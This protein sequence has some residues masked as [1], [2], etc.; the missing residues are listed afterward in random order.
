MIRR[1]LW[2]TPGVWLAFFEATGIEPRLTTRPSPGPIRQLEFLTGDPT[3]TISNADV[4]AIVH[5]PKTK[6]M[7]ELGWTR[8]R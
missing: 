1:S 7:V 3:C 4:V 5:P 2:T 8:R 6:W